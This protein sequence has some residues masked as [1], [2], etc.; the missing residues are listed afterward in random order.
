MVD[1]ADKELDVGEKHYAVNMNSISN[2]RRDKNGAKDLGVVPA[3]EGFPNSPGGF[4]ASYQPIMGSNSGSATPTYGAGGLLPTGDVITQSNYISEQAVVSANGFN[5]W[6]SGP[7]HGP[8]VDLAPME[9][10]LE[11][12]EDRILAVFERVSKH[13]EASQEKLGNSLQ[14]SLQ[15]VRNSMERSQSLMEAKVELTLSTQHK[16]HQVTQQNIQTDMRKLLETQLTEF[17]QKLSEG[18]SAAED[19]RITFQKQAFQ[20]FQKCLD[21]TKQKVEELQS[22]QSSEFRSLGGSVTQMMESWGQQTIQES[23]AAAFTL[24]KQMGVMEEVMSR[25]QV[26]DEERLASRIQHLLTDGLEG[27]RKESVK[28]GQ[29]VEKMHA[30]IEGSKTLNQNGTEKLEMK[31]SQISKDLNEDMKKSIEAAVSIVGNSLRSQLEGL[32]ALQLANRMESETNITSK[33]DVVLNKWQSQVAQQLQHAVSQ[34]LSGQNDKQ[35][36]KMSFMLESS[37]K[38]NMEK[39]CRSQTEGLRDFQRYVEDATRNQQQSSQDMH[40]VVLATKACA[41]ECM[42][43]MAVLGGQMGSNG[44]TEG[45]IRDGWTGNPPARPSTAVREN[46]RGQSSSKYAQYGMQVM[47]G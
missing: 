5:K 33:L 26:A 23:K 12:F 43:R 28:Q 46:S 20:G 30:N 47:H 39:A 19:S 6:P 25:K 9:K 32:Q 15:D 29:M 40:S 31:L 21:N 34:Q 36:D 14:T 27:L 44:G 17:N 18:Q 42:D 41:T 4:Q 8:S 2:K 38:D 16:E 24:Q 1:D 35:N 10:K 13:M 37:I 3:L 7:T 45:S 11:Q 22:S